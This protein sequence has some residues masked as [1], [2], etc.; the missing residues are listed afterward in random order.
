MTGRIKRLISW[1]R[2]YRKVEPRHT[3]RI[4]TKYHQARMPV[5]RSKE[6]YKRIWLGKKPRRECNI[7]DIRELERDGTIDR[8]SENSWAG[9]TRKLD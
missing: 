9:I 6:D 2:G 3:P 4:V 7:R 1:L 5:K 8:T